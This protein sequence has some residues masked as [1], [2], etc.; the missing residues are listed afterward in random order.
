[1]VLRAVPTVKDLPPA[2]KYM[3]GLP[4]SNLRYKP[5][6][7]QVRR[8]SKLYNDCQGCGFEDQCVSVYDV[9]LGR[10]YFKPGPGRPAKGEEL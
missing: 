3:V 6:I 9:N 5:L 7:D 1:M 8:C 2:L 10:L 4:F